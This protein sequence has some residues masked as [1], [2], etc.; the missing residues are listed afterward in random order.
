[1]IRQLTAALEE[2]GGRIELEHRVASVIVDGE[3]VVG[4]GAETPSGERKIHAGRAVVFGSGGFAHNA[5]LMRAYL[6]GP[7]VGGCAAITNEG[8]FVPIAQALGAEMRNMS[9]AWNVP[10]QLERA[11]ARDPTL[12]GTFNIVGDSM[13]CVNRYGRRAMNEKSV[14]NEA[15]VAMLAFDGIRCE[16]PN[17]LMFAIFDRANYSRTRSATAR[18]MAAPCPL[19]APMTTM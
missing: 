7:V 2:R 12:K 3:C 10:I 13:L 15:T 14:Y 11:L 16:Y 9:E 19:S 18:S 5:E 6:H 8:D 1:M 4:V 17:M